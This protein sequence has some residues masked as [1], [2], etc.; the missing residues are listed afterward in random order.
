V[1][2]PG[3]ERVS[4]TVFEEAAALGEPG[5]AGMRLARGLAPS[6]MAEPFRHVTPDLTGLE[7]AVLRMRVLEVAR[8]TRRSPLGPGPVLWFALRLRAQVVD[9]QRIVWGAALAT[10]PAALAAALVTAP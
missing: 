8:L 1:F 10:P 7:E 5:A 2:L 3:G 4:I 6:M 9:L